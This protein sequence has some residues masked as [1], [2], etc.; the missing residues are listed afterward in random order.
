MSMGAGAEAADRRQING[1]GPEPIW[2]AL[3]VHLF[4]SSHSPLW[5]MQKHTSEHAPAPSLLGTNR[6]RPPTLRHGEKGGL[7]ESALPS[8]EIY[9]TFMERQKASRILTS[10]QEMRAPERRGR[11]PRSNGNP[12]SEHL[13]KQ[14]LATRSSSADPAWSCSQRPPASL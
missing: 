13:L 1:A 2:L 3:H 12:R 11:G 5:V 4:G 10:L 8:P 9:S 6:Y 14:D 7:G